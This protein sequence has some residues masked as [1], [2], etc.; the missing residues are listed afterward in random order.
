MGLMGTRVAEG[1]GGR[2]VRRHPRTDGLRRFGI[3]AQTG[4]VR[5]SPSGVTANPA[6]GAVGEGAASAVA[7]A[8][9]QAVGAAQLDGLG[10]AGMPPARGRYCVPGKPMTVPHIAV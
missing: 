9:E 7:D 1:S 3:A 8:D 5:G 2:C 10:S 4:R 6:T